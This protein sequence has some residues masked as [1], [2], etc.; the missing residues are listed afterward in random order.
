LKTQRHLELALPSKKTPHDHFGEP[1][2]WQMRTL[3]PR[4]ARLACSI[5]RI[6]APHIPVCNPSTI[7]TGLSGN[8]KRSNQRFNRLF[9]N[10]NLVAGARNRHY[11]LFSAQELQAGVEQPD[12]TGPF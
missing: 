4:I 6:G 2:R 5:W 12:L 7:C 3:P 10:Q 11:L 8:E 9:Y 1:G